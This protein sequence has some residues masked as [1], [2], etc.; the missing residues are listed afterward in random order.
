MEVITALQIEL[1]ENAYKYGYHNRAADFV[2]LPQQ[3][4]IDMILS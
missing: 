2:D 1:S 3:T 4:K